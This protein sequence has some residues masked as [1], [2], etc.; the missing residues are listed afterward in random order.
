MRALIKTLGHGDLSGGFLIEAELPSLSF[1]LFLSPA[2]RYMSP[3]GVASIRQRFQKAQADYRIRRFLPL[4]PSDYS[5]SAFL[6]GEIT[7]GG[8]SITVAVSQHDY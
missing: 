1:S 5:L 8:S 7:N 4:S 6:S 2:F 3:P